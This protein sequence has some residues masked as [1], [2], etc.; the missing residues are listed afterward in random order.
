[1][2]IRTASWCF[3]CILDQVSEVASLVLC[4]LFDYVCLLELLPQWSHLFFFMESLNCHVPLQSQPLPSQ[5]PPPRFGTNFSSALQSGFSKFYGHMNDLVWS[6]IMRVLNDGVCNRGLKV[7]ISTISDSTLLFHG[8]YFNKTGFHY[9][10]LSCS[11]PNFE[12]VHC[13]MSGSNCC[14]LIC[15]KFLRRQVKYLVLPCL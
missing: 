9:A 14:F 15:Y 7:S 3:L 13:S 6:M 1:M 5:L 11:F 10:A 8:R 2:R 12:P 4:D